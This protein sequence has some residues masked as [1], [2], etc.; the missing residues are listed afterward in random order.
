MNR[1]SGAE[2]SYIAGLLRGIDL[3]ASPLR[4]FVTG[5]DA[6]ARPQVTRAVRKRIESGDKP[7]VTA[8]TLDAPV[9]AIVVIAD[10]QALTSDEI[11]ALN[12]LVHRD[13]LGVVIASDRID[14]PLAPIYSNI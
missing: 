9:D 12:E 3:T 11:R 5:T 10:A 6:S 7:V 2:S 13:D 14:P 4:L 8:V 1:D